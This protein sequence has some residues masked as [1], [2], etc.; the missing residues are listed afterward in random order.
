MLTCF[1]FLCS[2]PEVRAQFDLSAIQVM[3][4]TMEIKE[5]LDFLTLVLESNTEIYYKL[6][7]ILLATIPIITFDHPPGWLLNAV[8][9][10]AFDNLPW[11]LKNDE[12]LG[13]IKIFVNELNNHNST[14]DWYLKDGNSTTQNNHLVK[15]LFS[16]LDYYGMAADIL[17]LKSIRDFFPYNS[18]NRSL[19]KQCYNDMM[20]FAD[21]LLVGEEWALDMFDAIGKPTT[22][23]R[24]GVLYFIGTYDQCQNVRAH[25][26]VNDSLGQYRVSNESHFAGKYCRATFVPPQGLVASIAG[27]HINKTYGMPLTLS[28][29]MCLPDSCHGEDIEGLL[30]L[31][32]LGSWF[33]IS[34]EQAV[35]TE[36]QKFSQDTNS[37]IVIG[38]LGALVLL[39]ALSSTIEL[40]FLGLIWNKY[41]PSEL[42]SMPEIQPHENNAYDN[43]NEISSVGKMKENNDEQ[44]RE[45]DITTKTTK[46]EEPDLKER[47]GMVPNLALGMLIDSDMTEGMAFVDQVKDN[48]IR[49]IARSFSVFTNLPA[50]LST[51]TKPNDIPCLYGIRVIT[52]LWILLGNTYIY[53]TQTFAEVPVALD[54]MDSYDLME[55]FSMQAV[56]SA[57]YATDTFFMISGCL[58]SYWFLTKAE[59]NDDTVKMKT[60]IKFFIGKY[61]K[62]T[63]PY[64]L[65]MVIFVYLYMYLGHGPLW[66]N[67]LD[68]ADKCQTG[69]WKHL[70]YVNNVVG[71]DGVP[72]EKQC[73]AWSWYLAVNMQFYLISPILLTFTAFSSSMG[74]T[75]TGLLAVAGMVASGMKEAQY[76]GEILTSRMDNGDYWNYVFSKPWCR[77]SSYCVGLLLGFVLQKWPHKKMHKVIAVL[78]W[79]LAIS[80]GLILVYSPYSKFV[81]D[82]EPWTSVQQAV[83]EALGRPV[84]ALSVAWVVYACCAGFAGPLGEFLSWKGFVPLSR[85]TFMV[86]LN[87]PILIVLVVYSRRTLAHLNDFEMAYQFVGHVTV[88]YAAA[89]ILSL[90]ID[91]PF[92]N[93]KRIVYGKPLETPF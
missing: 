70:L 29:G 18:T 47:F 37:H 6:E 68:A 73:M 75:L 2:L 36:D 22:G 12:F 27:S 80:L 26:S 61:W 43:F 71:V 90:V 45:N 46:I 93:L 85:I 7:N 3:L 76:G 65:T 64:M 48:V 57:S 77:V 87:H 28:I 79:V 51:D 8:L 74:L 9:P 91:I 38:I 66:P 21:R 52:M 58:V 14:A 17:K 86:Y 13:I 88:N 16:V 81:R 53:I 20:T 5:K 50:A 19:G 32:L 84:W 41:A 82:L 4:Q 44:S 59:T 40:C 24:R 56:M 63:P 60:W 11:L 49:K 35:C 89:L 10:W 25:Q 1:V 69:W 31:G 39:V 15:K 42:Y 33:N 83:Y 67:R 55:R 30:H 62:M 72:A 23:I 78:C 34:V 92:R 54:L